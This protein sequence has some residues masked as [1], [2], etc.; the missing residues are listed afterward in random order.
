[1]GSNE[2]TKI[3]D[4]TVDQR[5]YTVF[6]YQDL[7][8]VEAWHG[9]IMVNELVLLPGTQQALRKGDELKFLSG[10]YGYRVA[11]M[12]EGIF[13]G[14]MDELTCAICYGI[15]FRPTTI[16]PCG[17][18][19]CV[20]C[21]PREKGKCHLCRGP[22]QAKVCCLPL[23]NLITGMVI[24]EEVSVLWVIDIQCLQDSS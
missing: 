13:E 2:K 15:L 18:T 23:R 16:V 21:M 11:S 20:T 22:M 10:K 24:R 9:S 3:A 6:K 4:P 19:F 7:W 1:M 17:H 14:Y 8:C 12:D 5:A